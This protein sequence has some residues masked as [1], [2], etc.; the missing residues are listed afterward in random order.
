[1]K[2]RKE[3]EEGRK[4]IMDYYIREGRLFVQLLSWSEYSILGGGGGRFC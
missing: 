2:K 1:M 3:E 4:E